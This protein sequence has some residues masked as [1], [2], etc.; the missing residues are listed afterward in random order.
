[1]WNGLLLAGAVALA[2]STAS[3]ATVVATWRGTV[4][5]SYDQTGVFLGGDGGNKQHANNG[6][7]FT[8]TFGFGTDTLGAFRYQEPDSSDELYVWEGYGGTNPFFLASLKIRTTTAVL[9]GA[10]TATPMSMPTG[11]T[12]ISLAT[13]PKVTP[14]TVHTSSTLHQLRH[15]RHSTEPAHQPRAGLLARPHR[16]G[17]FWL[18]L[19]L[20]L[21]LH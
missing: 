18:L 16:A 11:A 21:C 5:D 15:L 14:V 10:P 12:R 4:Y 6:Q 2:A 13:C 20:R 8:L 17:Q 7:A 9:P 3:G 19:V 1:M